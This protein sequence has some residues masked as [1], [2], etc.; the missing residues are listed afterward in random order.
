MRCLEIQRAQFS[1]LP[2]RTSAAI[3]ASTISDSSGLVMADVRP[4]AIAMVRNAALM[5]CRFGSPKL[6]LEAPHVVLTPSS[7]RSRRS[8]AIT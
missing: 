7:S 3:T 2:V 4:E 8:S 5:P 1:S 6:T